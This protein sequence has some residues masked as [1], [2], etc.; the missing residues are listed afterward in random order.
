MKEFKNVP[1]KLY[2]HAQE[3]V[4][5]E[6]E[7]TQAQMKARTQS[8]FKRP[9]SAKKPNMNYKI[10]KT[11][12]LGMFE[13]YYY[14]KLKEKNLVQEEDPQ[15]IEEYKREVQKDNEKQINNVNNIEEQLNEQYESIK[16]AKLKESTPN[17]NDK[18]LLLPK[19]PKNYLKENKQLIHEH[20]VP[21]K[22]KPKEEKEDPYHKNY[23]K[24]PEYINKMKYEAEIQKEV[25]RRLKE[26]AKYPKGT[27]LLSE[28]ERLMT[29][30]GLYESQKEIMG[31]IEKLP[32][33]LRTMASKNKKDELEKKLDE[34]EEAIKTFSRKQVFI[35][36]DS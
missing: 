4:S 17:C 6:K 32:I 3:W 22:I 23:G 9:Q 14:D 10:D 35:K 7:L 8:G 13:K 24:T 16:K 5:N 21:Y 27:R 34:I 25:Q 2:T 12:G 28:E 26:E 1:S 31:L 20:K 29:L 15:A 36:V 33:T 11:A 19:T 30:N 18:G